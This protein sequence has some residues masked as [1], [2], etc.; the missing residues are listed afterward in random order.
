MGCFATEVVPLKFRDVD[1]LKCVLLNCG[2]QICQDT[3]SAAKDHSVKILT[4]VIVH[5][6][7]MVSVASTGMYTI[8]SLIVNLK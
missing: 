3:V 8:L 6:M 5:R 2:D 1:Y 4:V 7:G